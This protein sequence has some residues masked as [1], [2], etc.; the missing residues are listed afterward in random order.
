L[1]KEI[2]DTANLIAS[3]LHPL[4]QN[5]LKVIFQKYGFNVPQ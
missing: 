5:E 4:F 1:I 3:D 2:K